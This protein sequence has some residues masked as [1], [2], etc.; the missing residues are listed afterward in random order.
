MWHPSGNVTGKR[1]AYGAHA[2]AVMLP[3]LQRKALLFIHVKSSLF[4]L[5]FSCHVFSKQHVSNA[6][7]IILYRRETGHRWPCADISVDIVM[8]WNK[9]WHGFVLFSRFITVISRALFSYLFTYLFSYPSLLLFFLREPGCQGCLVTPSCLLRSVCDRRLFSRSQ[10]C[11][12]FDI[13][14]LRISDTKGVER[15]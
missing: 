11:H 12:R 7:W 6:Q 10:R 15:A 4:S 13:F 5:I 3:T 8:K 2:D 9:L 1:A 14:I